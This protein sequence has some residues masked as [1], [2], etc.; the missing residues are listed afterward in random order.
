MMKDIP[1][2]ADDPRFIEGIFN[3]CDRWCE[4]CSF[5]S[6]CMLY[7][8]EEG[9]RD[10]L[11]AHDVN[12]EVF[13][14]RLSSIFKQTQEMI[15]GIAV[16]HG[17]DLD[18]LNAGQNED[19]ESRRKWDS[20][21]PLARSALQY[22]SLVNEWFDNEYA[23][24]RQLRDADAAQEKLPLVDFDARDRAS[25]IQEAVAVIRW[26]E[27]QIAVKI[28]RGLIRED[29]ECH[30][31]GQQALG[32]SAKARMQ[33]DSDGAAKVALIGIERSINAWA[34]LREHLPRK[35]ESIAPILLHLEQLRHA[36]E[37]AF[38]K[39]QSFVRPGFDEAPDQFVS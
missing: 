21:D 39:A 9:E 28:N 25:Q 8:M 32:A 14:N 6:R 1:N 22:I 18:A 24:S 23:G 12:S 27:F 16:E 34:R 20:G 3:Y 10:D 2:Q 7:M 36:T 38:P 31:S 30:D 5:T 15:N 33:S 29:F 11:A 26:Y 4:R 19:D 37:Q 35:A 17:I 13:R